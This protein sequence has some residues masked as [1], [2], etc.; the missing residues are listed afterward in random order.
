MFV[1]QILKKT[2]TKV[3]IFRI[4]NTYGPGENLNNLKKGMV[5]IYCS[6]IWKKKPLVIKGSLDRYRN[7]TYIS[8]CVEI[9]SK[10]ITNKKLGNFENIIRL[11]DH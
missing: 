1:D 3:R 5:S 2:N 6:Y 8:D 4:F 11:K 7:L 10:S 9:L